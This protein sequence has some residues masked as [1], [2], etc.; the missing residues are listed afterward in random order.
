MLTSIR[1][2]FAS[3]PGRWP[4]VWRSTLETGRSV[5]NRVNQRC[6]ELSAERLQL[7]ADLAIAQ[8]EGER[9]RSTIKEQHET[10]ARKQAKL[11]QA[12]GRISSLT[13]QLRALKQPAGRK[14]RG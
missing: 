8:H 6:S 9:M 1:E 11:D 13:T 14:G 10:I 3:L 5:L 4:L 2:W 12:N 7:Q